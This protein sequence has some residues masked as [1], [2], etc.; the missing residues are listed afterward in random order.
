[1][2]SPLP[3]LF[4]ALPV[5]I[6]IPVTLT[7]LLFILTIFLLIIPMMERSMMDGKRETARHL[8]ETAWSILAFYHDKE[9]RGLISG[10]QARRTAVA[11]LE[12][13]RYGDDHKDY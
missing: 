1:M 6:I 8:T 4:Q 5:R 3:G 7:I 9:I 13:L 11:L 12:Q 2:T 10:D